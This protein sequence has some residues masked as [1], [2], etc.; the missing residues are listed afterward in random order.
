[1]SERFVRSCFK[2]VKID[3]EAEEKKVKDKYSGLSMA[4]LKPFMHKR[5]FPTNGKKDEWLR[6]L[7][8]ARDP[9]KDHFVYLLFNKTVNKSYIGTTN[10]LELREKQHNGEAKGGA[11]YTKA[12]MGRGRSRIHM[13]SQ[14]LTKAQAYRLESLTKTGKNKENAQL[15][16]KISKKYK[17]LRRREE[18]LKE[19]QKKF[20][21]KAITMMY[22]RPK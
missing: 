11:K 6:L 18:I 7:R 3:I 14:N 2:N 4:E 12:I 21:P 22:V 19:T 17:G 16:N 8:Y 20:F 13:I 5:G 1:M 9:P 15:I 10:N